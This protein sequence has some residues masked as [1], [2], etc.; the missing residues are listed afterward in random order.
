MK[1]IKDKK[2]LTPQFMNM[3]HPFRWYISFN[4]LY[5]IMM[6]GAY[7]DIPASSSPIWEAEIDEKAWN[8]INQEVYIKSF[9]LELSIY[10]LLFFLGLSNMRNHPALAK[11]VFLSPYFYLLYSISKIFAEI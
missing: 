3:I 2:I 9:R 5:L 7:F 4:I 11:T 6:I 8:Y 1:N 10:V